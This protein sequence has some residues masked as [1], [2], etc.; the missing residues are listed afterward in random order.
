[1]T[2]KRLK[3]IFPNTY[4]SD[5]EANK[6]VE[7]FDTK[8][9]GYDATRA[10][11][12]KVEQLKEAFNTF[13]SAPGFSMRI[14]KDLKSIDARVYNIDPLK[15][16]CFK[17]CIDLH[18]F[19]K[20]GWERAMYSILVVYVDMF[21]DYPD[22]IE[23]VICYA[24][25]RNEDE[26]KLFGELSKECAEMAISGMSDFLYYCWLKD[27][28]KEDEEPTA[29]NAILSTGLGEIELTALHTKLKDYLKSDL[30]SWLYWFSG[31]PTI[32]P[33]QLEWFKTAPELLYFI[34]RLCPDD[35]K[36]GERKIKELNQIFK[37]TKGKKIS[38]N[39]SS[40]TDLTKRS[41]I[42]KLFK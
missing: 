17:G 9:N 10:V 32:K 6:Q 26:Q 27:G 4:F 5:E 25:G 2:T 20:Y 24:R 36:P 15:L 12:Y 22:V 29:T 21:K 19:Y 39:Q 40:T 31:V 33:K 30:A 23:G 16:N 34:E 8:L 11:N 38:N 14:D 35:F 18:P 42:N 37:T 3:D 7:I 41:A 28:A 1:M 13:R